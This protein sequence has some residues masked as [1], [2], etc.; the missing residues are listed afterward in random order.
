[1][2]GRLCVIRVDGL[3]Q[4]RERDPGHPGYPRLSLPASRQPRLSILLPS[5]MEQAHFYD[6]VS[7]KLCDPNFR[8]ED[9]YRGIYIIYFS[10]HSGIKLFCNSFCGVHTWNRVQPGFENFTA[11]LPFFVQKRTRVISPA[12]RA[13]A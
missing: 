12:G 6:S 13:P 9:R 3:V 7:I 4:K 11:M 2:M 8:S 1:M 10:M 5:C